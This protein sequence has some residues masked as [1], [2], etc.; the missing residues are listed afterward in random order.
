MIAVDWGTSSLRAYR[1]DATGEVVGERSAA[2]PLLEAQGRFGALLTAQIDGWDDGLVVMAGMIGSRSGWHE[3]PYVDVPAGL[4][5]I[6]AGLVELPP[7]ALPGRRAWIAPGLAQRDDGSAPEVMR[8]EETQVL[9]LA[10]RLGGA[11]PHTVC[12]PGTHSKWVRVADGRIA[13]LR[14][15]MTG[16]VYALLR[17]HGLLAALM[18]ADP[19]ADADAPAAFERGVHD[20]A[21]PGGLLHHLFAVRTRGLFGSLAGTEAASFLSGLLIGHEL[22]ALLPAEG[23]PVHLVGSAALQARY[24]RALRLLGREAVPHREAAA[25]RGLWRLARRAGLAGHDHAAPPP[26]P[27]PE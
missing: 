1:L 26:G 17:R 20:S 9:G 18:P 8:G 27:A 3:V 13:G 21:A 10:D 25:A 19:A 2:V 6:A 14:T 23:G 5:E 16:E 11:G 15:A 24:A 12:L 22:R 4:D 7:G